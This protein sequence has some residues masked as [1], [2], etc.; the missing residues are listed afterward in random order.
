MKTLLELGPGIAS[1]SRAS[2]AAA[3]LV[4]WGGEAG[5]DIMKNC[6][7]QGLLI[8]KVV[9]HRASSYPRVGNYVVRAQGQNS[10]T[11]FTYTLN[12][13][14]ARATTSVPTGWTL[15]GTCWVLKKDGSC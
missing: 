12:D 2:N 14:N 1:S 8:W 4:G 10:M 9:I 7:K 5:L 15:V 6:Q 3:G 11:G 13:Q